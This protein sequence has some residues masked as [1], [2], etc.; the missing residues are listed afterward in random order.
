MDPG[1]CALD[2]CPIEN[3]YIH[4]Q[5]T[6]PGNS[7]YLALFGILLLTQLIQ[8]VFFCAALY[9]LLGQIIILYH[10]EDVSRLKPRNYAIFFVSCDVIAL[11]LQSAGGALT[12]TAE[13]ADGRQMGLN[14]MIAGLAFQVAALTLFIALA[15]EFAIRLR[16]RNLKGEY[17]ISDSASL[18]KDDYAA[19]RGKKTWKLFLF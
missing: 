8:P 14:V 19:I 7:V 18:R 2:T 10:G 5:P 9:L 13:D 15:S 12:S 6:I 11:I 4:Y 1:L 16:R 3:A 17:Q